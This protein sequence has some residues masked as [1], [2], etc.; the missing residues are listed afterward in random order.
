MQ[1]QA[2][3]APGGRKFFLILTPRSTW[4]LIVGSVNVCTSM[5]V[6]QEGNDKI[7]KGSS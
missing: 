3:R 6:K 2:R 1:G 5:G 7:I 4:E